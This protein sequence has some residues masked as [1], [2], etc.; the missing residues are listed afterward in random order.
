MTMNL[1]VEQPNDIAARP[2][3]GDILVID[4]SRENVRLLAEIL[5]EQGYRVRMAL[6]GTLGLQAA[7]LAP[8]DMILLDIHMPEMDGFEVCAQLKAQTATE[9]IPII[10]CSVFDQTR[11]YLRAFNAGGI[12]YISKPYT[13]SEVLARVEAHLAR[14]H[15]TAQQQA[16]DRSMH[17]MR[18]MVFEVSLAEER[19]RRRIAQRLHEEVGQSLTRVLL[20][21][22]QLRAPVTDP[23]GSE[24]LE[25]IHDTLSHVLRT[26]RS[27]TSELS[28]PVLHE[29]GLIP[30]LRWLALHMKEQ[31]GLLVTIQHDER[32]K[33]LSPEANVQ[34]FTMVR[35]L[36]M[37]VVQHAQAH[38]VTLTCSVAHD[39]LRVEVV[40]DGVGFAPEVPGAKG[41]G[42]CSIRERLRYAQ[43]TYAIWS[44]P[45]QGT[46]VTLSWPMTPAVE[47][48]VHANASAPHER[49]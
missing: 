16:M 14:L 30:A 33:P 17:D 5:S 24:I 28:S 27:L 49:E 31:Y 32:E 18:A 34:L 15:S 40:D 45:G 36:L 42:L 25:R 44:Q 4:D 11:D 10:F 22:K 6:N 46:R 35:E 41:M 37:N 23:A 20:Q 21:V 47:T 7:R 8:P 43:G 19:E 3:R 9:H 29:L 1:T 13:V 38:S 26:T 2:S 12:D 39:A 48:A